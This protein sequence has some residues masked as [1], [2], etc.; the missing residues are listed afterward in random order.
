MVAMHDVEDLISDG[1]SIAAS[2]DTA[3]HVAHPLLSNATCPPMSLDKT[4]ASLSTRNWS[5]RSIQDEIVQCQY[6]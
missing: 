2:A 1:L 5:C 4:H 3:Q 6:S